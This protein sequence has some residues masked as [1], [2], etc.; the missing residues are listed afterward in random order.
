M[1]FTQVCPSLKNGAACG[2]NMSSLLLSRCLWFPAYFFLY[3][4]LYKTNITT[5]PLP[6][7]WEVLLV[8][9]LAASVF[10][11][12]LWKL[13]S[14]DSSC[15]YFYFN[16]ETA[17]MTLNH[18]QPQSWTRD[19]PKN[20]SIFRFR[21]WRSLPVWQDWVIYWPLGKFLK[22]FATINLLKSPTF[23]G[24]FCKGVKINHFPSEI[25]FGQLLLAFFSGHA[26]ATYLRRIP[27]HN[28]CD[29]IQGAMLTIFLS[30]VA[31]ISA[32]F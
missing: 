14:S 28:Q 8:A 3:F 2:G 13:I 26:E 5:A 29:Q 9:K 17:R 18:F 19:A 7:L 31:K 6:S 30:K 32:N 20:K 21:W 16:S 15:Y 11:V 23:L 1:R 10:V 25:I 12:C 4:R 22:P 27:V 24:N